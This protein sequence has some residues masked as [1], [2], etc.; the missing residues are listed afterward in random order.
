MDIQAAAEAIVGAEGLT[1]AQRRARFG[2]GELAHAYPRL[3]ELCCDSVRPEQRD[4]VRQLLPRMVGWA[5]EVREGRETPEGAART[6]VEA[7][8]ERYVDPSLLRVAP[9]QNAP[10]SAP[11]SPPASEPPPPPSS[12]PSSGAAP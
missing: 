10:S 8:N 2:G 3:F 9:H 1:P 6:V 4:A 12:S 5:A 11:E 7:L